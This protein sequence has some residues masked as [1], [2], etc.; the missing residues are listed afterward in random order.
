LAVHL[1]NGHAGEDVMIDTPNNSDLEGLTRRFA[2]LAT[3]LTFED[4]P[5]PVVEKAKLIVRD[6]IGIQIAESV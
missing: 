1:K 2:E 6:S 4:L 5:G 3:S